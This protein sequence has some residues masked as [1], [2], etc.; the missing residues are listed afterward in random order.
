ME[1]R[2]GDE[3]EGRLAEAVAG[4]FAR[5]GKAWGGGVRGLDGKAPGHVGDLVVRVAI[6]RDGDRFASEPRVVDPLNRS[7]LWSSRLTAPVGDLSRLRE[8]TALAVAGLVNCALTLNGRDQPLSTDADRRSL[9]FAI[10]DA[11]TAP[12]GS[13]AT[14]LLAQFV[15][16]W[17]GH[18]HP[19]AI[20]GQG[21]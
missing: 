16:P 19:P 8:R 3:I 15:Q 13:R 9:T 1:G 14:R 2:G 17:P 11:N 7:I 21:P 18:A 5:F 4:D 12:A 10:C 6:E 20:L